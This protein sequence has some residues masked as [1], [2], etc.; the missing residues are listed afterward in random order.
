MKLFIIRLLLIAILFL[1][2]TY[3]VK[4]EPALLW[5]FVVTYIIEPLVISKT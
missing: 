2:F 5:A 3:V 4:T 1:L